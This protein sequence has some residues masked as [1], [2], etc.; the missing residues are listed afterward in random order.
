MKFS[1]CV[2]TCTPTP[3]YLP[4]CLSVYLGVPLPVVEKSQL[5]SIEFEFQVLSLNTSEP[6]VENQLL[7]RCC[8]TRPQIS[9]SNQCHYIWPKGSTTCLKN[10]TFTI[11]EIKS[12]LQCRIKMDLRSWELLLYSC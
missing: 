9:A 10:S 5:P 8:Y 7:S 11:K 2:C 6:G 1:V 4:V 3:Q 12:V